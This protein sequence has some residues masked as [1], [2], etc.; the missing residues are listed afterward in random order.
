M[1][2]SEIKP[3]AEKVNFQ[4]TY[5]NHVDRLLER[6]AARD[7]ALKRAVG[8]EFEVMGI[9]QCELVKHYGLRPDSYLIDVGCG[10]GH[11]EAAL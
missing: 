7:A 4:A 3:T 1:Q 6:S 8:D 9:L 11:G 10:S 2:N 5:R